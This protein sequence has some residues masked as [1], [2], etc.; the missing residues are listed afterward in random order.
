ML[1]SFASTATGLGASEAA[2]RLE[3]DGPNLIAQAH[4]T[5]FGILLAQLRNPLL[6]LLLAV[7]PGPWWLKPLWSFRQQVDVSSTFSEGTGARQ[8]RPRAPCSH[9]VCWIAIEA[10]TI[11]NAS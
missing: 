10:E 2:E 6:L 9:F 4:V 11:A 8:S 7:R 5:A 1:A 3:A